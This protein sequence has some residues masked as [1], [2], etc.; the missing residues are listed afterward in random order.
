VKVIIII[1]TLNEENS[2]KKLVYSLKEYLKQYSVLIV[3]DDS[4]DTTQSQI[5]KFK[6][7]FKK[8]NFIFKKKNFGI[9]SA[10]KDG[11]KYAIQRKYDACITMDAD[12]THDPKKITRMIKIIKTKKY[13]IVSTNRFYHNESLKKWSFYR[14]FLTKLRYYIVRILLNTNLDSSGNFR[15]YN[16]TKIKSKHFFLSKNK[17]YFYLIESLFYLEKLN[18]KIVEIPIILH[19]RTF[20]TSKMRFKHILASLISLLKLRFFN[21]NNF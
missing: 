18:Y 17:S 6:K 7:K 2:I 13:D 8:I 1:P 16:L 3:D 9:G 11:I 10:I 19:P 15:A 5:I 20:D 4:L 12:G 14:I 21:L